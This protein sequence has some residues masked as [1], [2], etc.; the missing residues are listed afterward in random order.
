M[1]SILTNTSATTAL[2]TL[3]NINSELSKT[4]ERISTGYKINSAKDGA[5]FF[6]IATTMRSDIKSLETVD[7]L[8]GVGQ[9][10]VD[11]AQVGTDEAIETTQ[12]IKDLLVAAK[13]GSA[14]KTL[15][16]SEITQ[17]QEQLVTNA[18]ASSYNGVNMLYKGA[19]GAGAGVQTITAAVTRDSSNN[20]GTTSIQIDSAS[21]L[22]IDGATAANG[23]LSKDRTG[24]NSNNYSI[25]GGSNN[26]TLTATT[27][28][29]QLSD[30]IEAVDGALKDMTKSSSTLGS[31]SNRIESSGDFA[32][33][34]KANLEAG[35]SR[36]VDTDM[37]EES[38]KLAAL[39][40]RQQ[41]GVQ[42]LSIANSNSQNI[43]SLFR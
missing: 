7:S 14:D 20:F 1:S 15:I 29:A 39:Q 6:S 23:I 22:L 31:V 36:L 40:V 10:K 9:A 19:T 38:A 41:L 5:A 12:K 17:L 16:Q 24:T 33:K 35:V 3:R 27:T 21:T 30:M 18:K 34:L 28:S 11:T 43:L 13:E 37:E 4:Q 2:Q 42:A 8:L 25:V 32:K 26:I